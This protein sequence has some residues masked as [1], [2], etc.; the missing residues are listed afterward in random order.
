MLNYTG[1]LATSSSGRDRSVF[2]TVFDRW[3]G[4]LGQARAICKVTI[5]TVQHAVREEK[6]NDLQGT[7]TPAIDGE[8]SI[9]GNTCAKLHILLVE[10]DP[11]VAESTTLILEYFGHQVAMASHGPAALAAVQIQ[12][13]DIVLLDI[14]MPKMDG[15][16]LA[17]QLRD[18]FQDKTPI[19][20]GIS[21]YG[22]ADL[23]KRCATAGIDILL[24]KPVDPEHL[25]LLLQQQCEVVSRSIPA[26][27]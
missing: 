21:G 11:D 5:E 6:R 1:R 14:R 24:L 23:E 19:L 7:S 3:Q 22:G 13:P 16:E 8:R 20:I 17:R 18:L 27:V 12:R 25:R 26:P 9:S 4:F 10:D 2:S 15:C